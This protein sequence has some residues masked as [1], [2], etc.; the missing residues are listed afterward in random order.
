MLFILSSINDTAKIQQIFRI[1]KF[2][3]HFFS[4]FYERKKSVQKKENF[5]RLAHVVRVLLIR[6]LGVGK[7]IDER[8]QKGR[9]RNVEIEVVV[10]NL[11]EI[12]EKYLHV[13]NIFFNFAEKFY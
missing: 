10:A 11:W 9:R 13:F 6:S 2:L 3:G 1:S 12:Y 8:L 4:F 7:R 5:L